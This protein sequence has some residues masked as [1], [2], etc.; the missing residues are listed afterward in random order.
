M[1]VVDHLFGRARGMRFTGD[2]RPFAPRVWFAAGALFLAAVVVGCKTSDEIRPPGGGAS[3]SSA[4]ST[5]SSTAA[6]ISAPTATPA[7]PSKPGVRVVKATSG[8]VAEQIAREL[9]EGGAARRDVIVYVGATW[10]EPCQRFHAAA[11]RGEL[12][13]AFPALTLVEFDFDRDEERLASA[14]Y[15]SKMIPLFALP[16]S[17]GR[18][19]GRQIE[20]SIKGPGAVDEITPRLRALLERVAHLPR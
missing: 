12:D 7:R 10:C 2:P 15:R 16:E 17:D 13:A 20:G 19:S 11:E 6:A 8:G 9:A 14:G 3:S 5:A 18:A 1:K 4:S